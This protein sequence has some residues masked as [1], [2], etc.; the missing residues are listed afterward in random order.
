[1]AKCL[2]YIFQ[3]QQDSFLHF[4]DN[5][6]GAFC[7]RYYPSRAEVVEKM[8]HGSKNPHNWHAADIIA[9]ARQEGNHLLDPPKQCP[10]VTNTRFWHEYI[11]QLNQRYGITGDNP[12]AKCNAELQKARAGLQQC[13]AAYAKSTETLQSTKTELAKCHTELEKSKGELARCKADYRQAVSDF[14][15]ALNALYQQLKDK[16]S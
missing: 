9:M 2:I 16:I 8:W 1:M 14:G 12:L 3:I 4:S 13:Q 5:Q 6:A 11:Q 10:D 15:K 7:L